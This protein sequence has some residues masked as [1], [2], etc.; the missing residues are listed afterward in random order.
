M[1]MRC[2]HCGGETRVV[3]T[4]R[5]AAETKRWMRCLVCRQITRTLEIYHPRKP[6]PAP[7][8]ARHGARARGEGHGASVLTE[9]NVRELR[10]RA[11]AGVPQSALAREFGISASHVS[12]IV[13][14]KAWSH[15]P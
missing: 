2:R 5:H 12:Q 4:E 9:A 7:G 10:A 13:R 15:L 3:C 1:A 11:Q 8:S 6:G 14:R